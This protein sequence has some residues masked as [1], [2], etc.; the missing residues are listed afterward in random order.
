MALLTHSW[1]GKQVVA[2]LGQT[3]AGLLGVRARHRFLAPVD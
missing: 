2:A 3:M 1:V